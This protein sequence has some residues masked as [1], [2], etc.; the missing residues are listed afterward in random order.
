[1]A[2]LNLY[3]GP[4]TFYWIIGDL[5]RE[6]ARYGWGNKQIWI[7][8]TNVEP[9]DDPSHRTGPTQ[10][11]VTMDEQAGFLVDA[12]AVSIAAGASRIEVY[13]MFDGAETA[14]GL[15]PMGIVSNRID[16]QTGQHWLRPI[17]YTFRFLGHL[18]KGA[19]GG[20]YTQG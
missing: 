6:L 5:R 4:S 14:H 8:E 1:M 13:R 18:F 16:P 2:N 12:F 20:S 17:A 15:P 7:S 9:Y 19:T 10:F 11:R 3:I